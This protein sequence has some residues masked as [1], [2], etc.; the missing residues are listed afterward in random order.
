[1]KSKL[2]LGC[3]LVFFSLNC[4]SRSHVGLVSSYL[5]DGWFEYRLRKI[6]DP[7]FQ[8]FDVVGFT[9]SDTPMIEFGPTPPDWELDFPDTQWGY[10]YVD[11]GVACQGD[12]YE[13]TFLVRS[14]HQTYK[15][16][17]NILA[18][19][20][21]AFVGGFHGHGISQNAVGFVTIDGLTPCPPEEADGSPPVLSTSVGI[22]DLPD[23]TLVELVTTAEGITAVT[24]AYNE[25]ATVRLERTTDFV[26]WVPV[27]YMHGNPGNTTWN[28][29]EPLPVGFYRLRLIAEGHIELPPV[30]QLA[31][32][33]GL[34]DRPKAMASSTAIESSITPVPEGVRVSIKTE[35]GHGYQ[36]V[37]R[38]TRGERLADEKFVAA[39]SDHTVLFSI[40]TSRGA[41]AEVKKVRGV[42]SDDVGH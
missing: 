17:T 18:L 35:P 36:V 5:G 10:N 37:V 23:P 6:E 14:S 1:M 12:S 38:D 33:G 29:E 42:A 9:M 20:S 21:F 7:F 4:Q 19:M 13:R 40:T 28:P 15:R 24:F 2:L 25:R 8:F 16:T 27:A 39:G 3:L 22:L 26:N 41:F 34:Q 31:A 32:H 30:T 11:C